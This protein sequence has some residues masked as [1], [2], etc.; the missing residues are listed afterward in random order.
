MKMYVQKQPKHSIVSILTM[1]PS[2]MLSE[3]NHQALDKLGKFSDLIFIF[4]GKGNIDR[5]KFTTLYQGTAWTSIGDEGE[6]LAETQFKVFSYCKEIF[7]THQVYLLGDVL[8]Q[9]EEDIDEDQIQLI[10]MSTIIKPIYKAHRLTAEETRNIYWTTDTTNNDQPSKIKLF[11]SALINK[12]CEEKEPDFNNMYYTWN[13]SSPLIFLRSETVNL[14]LK[15]IDQKYL[16]TFSDNSKF[17]CSI[18]SGLKKLGIDNI[19][20]NLKDIDYG[21]LSTE[22]GK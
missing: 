14:F 8:D 1:N 20:S 3:E 2:G 5:R 15:M 19:D 16:Q 4:L 13:T 7:N 9:K 12:G 6:N 17:S 18:I 11:W 10:S 21:N 22:G